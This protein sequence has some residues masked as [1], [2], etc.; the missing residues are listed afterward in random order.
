MKINWF[1]PLP[2][3]S[4]DIAHYT[5][6]VLPALSARAEVTLWTDQDGWDAA[7]RKQAAVR[8]YPLEQMPWAELNRGDISIYHMGNDPRFHGALWQVSRRHPGVVVLHDVSLHQFFDGLYRM[9]WHDLESYL[10]LM[11]FYYG[12]KGRSD[13]AE[14]FKH[15]GRNILYMAEH[16][17]LTELALENALGVLVHTQSA[18]AALKREHRWPVAYAPL[19]FASTLGLPQAQSSRS[20]ARARH[21]PYHL[22]VFGYIAR[23][24]RLDAVLT[25]LAELPEREQ[26]HLHI[27]GQI[28]D[29]NY[30]HARVDSLDLGQ[31]VTVHGFVPEDELDAALA[32][33]HLAINLRHPTMGEASGSQLRIWNHALPSLVTNTGWYAT[34]PANTVAFVR[35][36][37]EVAD[38]QGHLK[39]FLNDPARL[40]AMGEQGRRV[41]TE[42]HAPEAYVNVL[43]DLLTSAQRFRPRAVAERIAERAGALMSTWMDVANSEQTLRHVAAEIHTLSK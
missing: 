31:R 29:H 43:L 6:R 5:T 7:L 17:P 19:P 37:H 36:E 2:P 34:L 42:Q 14:C 18:F 35:P 28:W 38:I 12:Q 10:S 41:L 25:A 15:D 39:E 33:A 4:T 8:P 23:N 11:E 20:S 9:Q 16:Y 26:F 21:S 13:A 30:I 24:R 32:A 22:V 27:Y 40:A 3:A 1:S